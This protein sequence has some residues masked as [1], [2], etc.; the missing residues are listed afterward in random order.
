MVLRCKCGNKLGEE[1][2]GHYV[3]RHRKR[4]IVC[5]WLQSM[6]CERCGRIWQPEPPHYPRLVPVGEGQTDQ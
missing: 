1:H 2:A 6:R 4:E 5:L 3:I